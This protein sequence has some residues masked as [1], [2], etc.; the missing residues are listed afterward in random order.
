VRNKVASKGYI[1][2]GY[3]TIK[4]VT[5]C[6]KYLDNAPTFLNRTKKSGWS[7]KGGNTSHL[8]SYDIDTGSPIHCI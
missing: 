1:A 7:K 5:F 6:A 8:E 2:E 3:I 4:L